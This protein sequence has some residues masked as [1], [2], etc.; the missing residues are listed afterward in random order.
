MRAAFSLAWVMSGFIKDTCAGGWAGTPAS[1]QRPASA[2]DAHGRRQA[3]LRARA[4]I[5]PCALQIESALL[6]SSVPSAILRVSTASLSSLLHN[7]RAG[8]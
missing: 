4:A 5:D 2:A 1:P 8:G 7:R 6:L 3:A